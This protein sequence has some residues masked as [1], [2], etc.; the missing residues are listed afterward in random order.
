MRLT[1]VRVNHHIHERY[2][3]PVLMVRERLPANHMISPNVEYH[4]TNAK[5]EHQ[6]HVAVAGNGLVDCPV[7]GCSSLAR[8]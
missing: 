2:L 7:P 1:V 3:L 5:V 4:G 8:I 6:R